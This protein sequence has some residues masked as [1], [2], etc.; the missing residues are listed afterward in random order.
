M[1]QNNPVT[2]PF[3]CKLKQRI[4]LESS[5]RE[6]SLQFSTNTEKPWKESDILYCTKTWIS[7]L[8]FGAKGKGF[9]RG[10]VQILITK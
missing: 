1:L 9:P 4:S 7:L 2:Y 10:N 5:D 6:M 3:P 8:D